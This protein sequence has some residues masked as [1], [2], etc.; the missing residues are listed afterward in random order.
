[1][2]TIL[3]FSESMEIETDRKRLKQILTNLV[4]N[5]IK[6]T[7]QGSVTIM[8]RIE[9]RGYSLPRSELVDAV[10]SL[11]EVEPQVIPQYDLIVDVIDTGVGIAKEE[12]VNLFQM[13]GKLQ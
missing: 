13:F 5:A 1:M 9:R 12:M 3:K 10:D 11:T 8:A 2:V 6:F 7:D 4:V